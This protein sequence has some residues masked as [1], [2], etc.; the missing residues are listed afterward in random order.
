MTK[1]GVPVV[2]LVPPPQARQRDAANAIAGRR[3]REAHN[4]TLGGLSIREMIE[5]GRR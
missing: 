2:Q 4:V 1:Q 3:H 5:A